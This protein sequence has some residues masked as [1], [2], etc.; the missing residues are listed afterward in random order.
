MQKRINWW[1]VAAG[2]LALILIGMLA[3]YFNY[4]IMVVEAN[5]PKNEM[6]QISPTA[7]P[8]PDPFAPYSVLLLGYGGGT[9]D[10]GSLTDSIM[11]AQ[12]RPRDEE[13]Y[14]ISIPRDL[15]VPIPIS[16]SEENKKIMIS[17]QE[18][19]GSPDGT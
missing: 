19:A 3:A 16:E 6:T 9:H 1:W 4:N 12:I 5:K 13:V 8:T 10:G 18:P 11:L 2:I 15:W 14:L 7:T 17:N